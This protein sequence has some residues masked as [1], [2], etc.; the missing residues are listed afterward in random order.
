MT[1]KTDG[2]V[3][4]KFR[5]EGAFSSVGKYWEPFGVMVELGFKVLCEVY[6]IIFTIRSFLVNVLIKLLVTVP[7]A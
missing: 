4:F 6:T 2:R 7:R 3:G 5:K 1:A